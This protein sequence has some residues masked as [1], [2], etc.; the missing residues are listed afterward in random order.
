MEPVVPMVDFAGVTLPFSVADLIASG[1]GLLGLIGT[2]VLL[3]LAFKFAPKVIS[4]I[5]TA[6]GSSAR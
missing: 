2:F 3:G 6:F 1:N 5:R 4:L